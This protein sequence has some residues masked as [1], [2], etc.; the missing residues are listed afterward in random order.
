LVSNCRTAV[1]GFSAPF[2]AT[3]PVFF[4]AEVSKAVSFSSFAA[5]GFSNCSVVVDLPITTMDYPM[6]AVLVCSAPFRSEP[7][8]PNLHNPEVPIKTRGGR[9]PSGRQPPRGVCYCLSLSAFTSR[10][11]AGPA[12]A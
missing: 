2:S 1:V 6:H 7:I 9:R 10:A 3:R 12:P 4:P 11:A 8:A 5:S